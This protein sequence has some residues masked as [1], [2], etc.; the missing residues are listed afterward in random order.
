M[1]LLFYTQ[2]VDIYALGII[3]FEMVHP[4]LP[5]IME[6]VKILSDL[7]KKEIIFPASFDLENWTK[8]VWKNAT[9]GDLSLISAIFCL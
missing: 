2:K 3:F 9:E 8:E 6:R 5:T 1:L 4:P 7:R